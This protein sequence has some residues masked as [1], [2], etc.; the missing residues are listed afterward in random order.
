[1]LSHCILARPI[2]TLRVLKGERRAA[3]PL[4]SRAPRAELT[5]RHA[6]PQIV[7]A[8]VD[9]LSTSVPSAAEPPQLEPGA[10][11]ASR[12]RRERR[13][14]KKLVSFTPEE[15]QA[16]AA[17]AA[18]CGRTPGRFIREVSVGVVPKARRNGA[19]QEVIRQLA[20]I[21][22]NLNQLAREANASSRFPDEARIDAVLAEIHAII[23]R[24]G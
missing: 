19:E 4:R 18:E 22:N 14:A 17:R 15:L 5:A 21:G 8:P 3:A 13:T 1:M 11:P 2:R 12:R 10:R 9:V 24:L 7:R 23:G 6:P 16:V 20:R